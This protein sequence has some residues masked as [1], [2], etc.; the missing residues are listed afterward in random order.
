[1]WPFFRKDLSI[2]LLSLICFKNF[3]SDTINITV[4]TKEKNAIAIGYSVNGNQYGGLGNSYSG[5]GPKNKEYQFG[6]KKD[7]IFGK[8]ISCGSITLN[9]DSK[10]TLVNNN[11]QCFS[12]LG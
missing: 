1:M 8:D 5:K 3:A 12:V 4:I 10:V 11:N 2:V 7:S 6:Y 9:Q